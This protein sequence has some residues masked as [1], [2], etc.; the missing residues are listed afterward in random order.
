M[1]TIRCFQCKQVIVEKVASKIYDNDVLQA[2][3][4]VK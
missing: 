4:S 3:F 2:K 1:A